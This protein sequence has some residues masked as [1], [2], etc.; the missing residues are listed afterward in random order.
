MGHTIQL[1]HPALHFAGHCVGAFDFGDFD[2]D[3]SIKDVT[4]LSSMHRRIVS[5]LRDSFTW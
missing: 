4:V 5:F 3:P 1:G 2:P